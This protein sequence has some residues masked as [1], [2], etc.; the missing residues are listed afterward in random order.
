MRYHNKII[1]QSVTPRQFCKSNSK[2]GRH[3]TDNAEKKLSHA[4]LG[5]E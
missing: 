5:I 1:N 3:T 2:Q 4:V